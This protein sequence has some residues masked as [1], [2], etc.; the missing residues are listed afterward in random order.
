M[1]K[2]GVKLVAI[3]AGMVM[4]MTVSAYAGEW[5]QDA[6]GWWY[7]NEDGTYPVNQ[8]EWLDGDQ[9]GT[10]ESYYFDGNGYMLVNTTTPDGYQVNGNGAW[11]D[12]NGI[13]QTKAVAV[14][15]GETPAVENVEESQYTVKRLS[16]FQDW[17]VEGGQMITAFDVTDIDQRD[18]RAEYRD[19]KAKNFKPD[20]ELFVPEGMD[21][22]F[23]LV[24][25]ELDGE[26]IISITPVWIDS[27]NYVYGN[28]NDPD[29]CGREEWGKYE[30]TDPEYA[31]ELKKQLNEEAKQRAFAKY[32][33]M[34]VDYSD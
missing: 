25:V 4:M 31:A 30:K 34:I 24:E 2:F 32:P 19:A 29:I 14:Q 15:E 9:N 1:K 7:Q 5:K 11:I 17:K 18:P 12:G 6:T 13:V 10:A 20:Y 8:W 22:P 27:S 33:N 28:I 26:T 16:R 3:T 21:W 23:A